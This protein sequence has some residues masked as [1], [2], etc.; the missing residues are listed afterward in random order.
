MATRENENYWL[1]GAEPPARQGTGAEE[2]PGNSSHQKHSPAVQQLRANQ[3]GEPEN[4]Q[5]QEE[6]H[7]QLLDLRRMTYVQ[8]TG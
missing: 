4:Q 3:I 7:T 6:A 5:Q 2:G 1:R 8:E